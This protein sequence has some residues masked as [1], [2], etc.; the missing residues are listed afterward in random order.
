MPLTT[1]GI[2]IQILSSLRAHRDHLDQCTVNDCK[3]VVNH[4]IRKFSEPLVRAE[5][6]QVRQSKKVLAGAVGD[7]V[8]DHAVPVKVLLEQLLQ[9]PDSFQE[10]SEENL[11]RLDKFLRESLLIVEVTRDEDRILSR[12]GFQREM[13]ESWSTKGNALYQDPLARYKECRIDV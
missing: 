12:H 10:V 2:A 3:V 11:A 8:R 7:T 1:T 13:P 5:E 6:S 4:L 9:L